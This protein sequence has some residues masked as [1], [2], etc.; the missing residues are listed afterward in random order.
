MVRFVSMVCAGTLTSSSVRALSLRA[1]TAQ[2]RFYLMHTASGPVRLVRA[3]YGILECTDYSISDAHDTCDRAFHATDR[4]YAIS[5]TVCMIE[6]EVKRNLGRHTNW[7]QTQY[8]ETGRLL[9]VLSTLYENVCVCTVLLLEQLLLQASIRSS[10]LTHTCRSFKTHFHAYE[11]YTKQ[12]ENPRCI[13]IELLKLYHT[14]TYTTHARI[15]IKSFI[16][17]IVLSLFDFTLHAYASSSLDR[18]T[19]DKLRAVASAHR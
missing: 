13:N 9:V 15:N 1:N 8:S 3:I 6:V 14:H 18:Q 7:Q 4:W 19:T 5:N 10:P 12:E 2:R 11:T 17:E 16:S